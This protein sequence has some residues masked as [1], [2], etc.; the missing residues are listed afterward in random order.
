MKKKKDNKILHF[1][2]WLTGIIVSLSVGFAMVGGT[3][4]LPWWMGGLCLLGSC[5]Q[6]LFRFR[7]VEFLFLAL[8][9]DMQE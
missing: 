5:D 1:V 6:N 8:Q 4:T 2:T 3:L 9:A 7:A